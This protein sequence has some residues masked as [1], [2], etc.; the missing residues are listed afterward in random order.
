M[1]SL[2]RFETKHHLPSGQFGGKIVPDTV[3]KEALQD[4]QDAQ[5]I[6]IGCPAVCCVAAAEDPAALRLF[7]VAAADRG[8][9]AGRHRAAAGECP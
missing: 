9:R 1:C 7:A 4:E 6:G 3:M 8:N 5:G 2:L